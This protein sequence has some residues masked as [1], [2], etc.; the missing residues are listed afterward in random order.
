MSETKRKQYRRPEMKGSTVVEVRPQVSEEEKN[1]AAL[2]RG[3]AKL[4]GLSENLKVMG[5]THEELF[6]MFDINQQGILNMTAFNSMLKG[7][8]VNLE[9]TELLAVFSDIDSNR[10][11]VIS[12]NE[13]L[14]KMKTD[15]S[16]SKSQVIS[17]PPAQVTSTRANGRGGLVKPTP[18]TPTTQAQQD[19]SVAPQKP[20]RQQMDT[21]Y[22]KMGQ[23]KEGVNQSISS[24]LNSV[25]VTDADCFAG[26]KTILNDP[27][28][29][30]KRC[31]EFIDT[32]QKSGKQ[33]FED[34]EFGPKG[35]E[36]PHGYKSICFDPPYVGAPSED[37][38][39]WMRPAEIA[40]GLAVGFAP[41]GPNSVDVNQGLVGDCWM[42]SA[43]SIL[44]S[45]RGLLMG[46]WTP[47]KNNISGPVSEE[48]AVKLLS[49]VYPPIFHHLAKYGIYVL[50]FFKNFQ[51]RYVIIDDKIPVVQS[52][53][54]PDPV[55]ANSVKK[56]TYWVS[57]V[58]KAYAKLHKTYQSLISG[59]I[60][61]AL[62]DFTGLVSE[63]L[64]IQEK[65]KFND[66]VLKSKDAFWD[67]ISRVSKDGGLMG[68]A[69]NGTGIEHA[70][71]L[72][73]E[74]TGLVSGHA[75]SIQNVVTITNSD[76]G[77]PARLLRIRNP[78]GPKNPKEWVGAWSDNSTELRNNYQEINNQLKATYGK[79]AEL[80]DFKQNQEDGT[81][82]TIFEDFIA[83]WSRISLCVK[84]PR[85]YSRVRY[86]WAWNS[87]TAGGTPYKST[88]DQVKNWERNTQFY[89]S[90]TKKTNIFISLTQEDGRLK[91]TAKEVFPFAGVAYTM[92]IVVIE[93]TPGQ[94]AP[95]NKLNP[96]RMCPLKQSRDVTLN[97]DLEPG[98]Y[99]I[100]PST[101]DIGQEGNFTLSIYHNGGPDAQ[102]YNMDT[103]EPPIP[104][105]EESEV[106]QKIDAN[107]KSFLK[108]KASESYFGGS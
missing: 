48:E 80:V 31:Q 25:T 18:I 67:K 38:I 11:G 82:F 97:L 14:S 3:N 39:S 2:V 20:N 54:G 83:V 17:Q 66:K 35:L 87:K 57:F 33:Y 100:V 88:A 95:F 6:S 104:I 30:L 76:N 102:L 90:T 47:D 46:D 51:W 42:V 64:V 49:G 27:V 1:T 94:K 108:L 70:V 78:W 44:G 101:M 96:A 62:V 43:L 41:D 56:N 93:T 72:K 59:D 60:S 91:A 28:K 98:T 26:W 32:L 85:D 63:K 58:E 12:T 84:F 4:A 52:P 77:K 19:Q 53:T 107:L 61:D 24:Y 5:K 69:I 45:N 73:G 50:K 16:K 22:A 75:Y 79:Y 55:F 68:C 106:P 23:S 40:P 92:V 7:M 36:D 105:Q 9:Q 15:E 86:A 74:D 71:L 81:F 8:S 29:A 89:F 99:A 37:E 21:T 103:K 34:P 10:D 13:F 65:G